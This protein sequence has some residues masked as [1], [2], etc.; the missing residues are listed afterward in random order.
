MSHPIGEGAR[1]AAATKAGTANRWIRIGLGALV[2]AVAAQIA[3][4]L[5]FTPIPF[6]LQPLAVLIVGGLLGARA[7]A[8][9][10]VLYLGLGLMGLPVFAAGGSGVAR[11]LGPTG[12][13]LLAFPAAAG[14]VGW[15]V[16]RVGRVGQDGRVGR[17]GQVGQ[18]GPAEASLAARPAGRLAGFSRLA[19]YLVACALG[20]L[21]IHL[22]GTAQLA[23]L[24]GDAETAIRSGF[25]PFLTGD[26]LKIGL[27]VAV[28]LLAGPRLRRPS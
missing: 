19:A 4:P 5:P 21:V 14:L 17:G 13:Y 25:I 11:L 15:L 6:T 7:G 18:V 27:A 23:L 10:L 16:E 26:L 9:A 20:I 2:V 12:G 22:G 28:L 3:I 8:A 1:P 24:T